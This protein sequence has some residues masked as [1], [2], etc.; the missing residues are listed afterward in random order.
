MQIGSEKNAKKKTPKPQTCCG[1]GVRT[2]ISRTDSIRKSS[3][4]FPKAAYCEKLLLGL[5]S[6]YAALIH[7]NT[8]YFLPI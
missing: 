6:N 8:L 4:C 1:E 7:I 5:F 3:H 2:M